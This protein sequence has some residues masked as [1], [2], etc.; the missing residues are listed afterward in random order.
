PPPKETKAAS[1]ETVKGNEKSAPVKKAKKSNG[2]RVQLLGSGTIL[3]EVIAAS[4]LLES[5][6]GVTCDIWSCPS[7]SELRK[8]GFDCERWNRLHPED[9]Q[10][11]SH[12]THCLSDR[13]GPVVAATDY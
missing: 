3:R 6:F 5:E 11:V 2:P 1:K 8:D 4:E 12:V 7:F 13:D 10:R 9:K